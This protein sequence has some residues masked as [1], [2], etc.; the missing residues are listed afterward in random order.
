MQRSQG[1]GV[2]TVS[3]REL[4]VTGANHRSLPGLCT[5]VPALQY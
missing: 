1:D 3:P 2:T 4:P 5:Y